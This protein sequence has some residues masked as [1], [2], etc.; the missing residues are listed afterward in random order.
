MPDRRGQRSCGIRFYIRN[1]HIRLTIN[2]NIPQPIPSIHVAH[3]VCFIIALV[4]PIGNQF[5][6]DRV[7]ETRLLT[8][9]QKEHL[10]VPHVS[11]VKNERGGKLLGQ[12]RYRRYGSGVYESAVLINESL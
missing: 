9:Y 8:S 5:Y 6:S 3:D 2:D 1:D 12:A 4:N 7:S 10:V 11:T